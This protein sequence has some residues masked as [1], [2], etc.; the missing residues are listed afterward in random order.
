[1]FPNLHL[2]MSAG[3]GEGI[4]LKKYAMNWMKCLDLHR[5]IMFAN[6]LPSLGDEDHFTKILFLLEM[7]WNI[8]VWTEN[9]IHQ[10][11]NPGGVEMK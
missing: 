5:K 8:Q 6:F 10:T 1:M 4:S 7:E 11:P 9:Y 2:H 3:G